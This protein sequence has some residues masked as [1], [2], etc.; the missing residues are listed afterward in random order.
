SQ[1]MQSTGQTDTHAWSV[2]SIHGSV[3]TNVISTLPITLR[4][5]IRARP[6]TTGGLWWRPQSR[7]KRR[8]KPPKERRG[9]SRFCDID[10]EPAERLGIPCLGNLLRSRFDLERTDLRRLDLFN[11]HWR[12]QITAHAYADDEPAALRDGGWVELWSQEG[13][14]R[15]GRG[16]LMLWPTES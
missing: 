2:V 12:P 6:E 4:E 5:R 11:R 7:L 16:R 15:Y 9:T 8:H 3:M 13:E 10:C 14:R 1:W